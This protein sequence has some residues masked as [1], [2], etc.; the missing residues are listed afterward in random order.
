MNHR[1][2]RRGLLT[3]LAAL[4]LAAMAGACS[5]ADLVNALVPAG[6]YDRIE[7]LAYGPGPRHRLD[8]YRPLSEF[9][10]RESICLCRSRHSLLMGPRSWRS[11]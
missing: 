6:G 9:L 3:R 8:L 7:G 2:A 4:P 5:G 11:K 10:G 1:L